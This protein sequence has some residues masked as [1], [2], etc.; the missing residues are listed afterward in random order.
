MTVT[1]TMRLRDAAPLVYTYEDMDTAV[2][3]LKACTDLP[4]NAITGWSIDE[5]RTLSVPAPVLPCEGCNRLYTS[6]VRSRPH[7]RGDTLCNECC[8]LR[9]S[10]WEARILMRGGTVAHLR[11]DADGLHRW[12]PVVGEWSRIGRSLVGGREE[13]FVVAD[14]RTFT[15]GRG[16]TAINIIAN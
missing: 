11:Q 16:I 4:D 13:T 1:L 5:D 10:S 12:E 3:V 2:R 15:L 7:L 14:D 6:D 8:I 9:S